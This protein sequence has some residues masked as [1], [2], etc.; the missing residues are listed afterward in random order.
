VAAGGADD[1][2]PVGIVHGDGGVFAVVL[3][4][5]SA[6]AAA[7]GGAGEARR[8]WFA[9]LRADA[10]GAGRAW[11]ATAWMGAALAAAF[12]ALA[13]AGWPEMPP[14]AAWACLAGTAW[15][16]AGLWL[17]RRCRREA[18][19]TGGAHYA[20]RVALVALGIW[21]LWGWLAQTSGVLEELSA[22][23]LAPLLWGLVLWPAG[24]VLGEALAASPAPPPRLLQS[25]EWLVAGQRILLT[26]GVA[27]VVTGILVEMRKDYPVDPTVP[28]AVMWSMALAA[29]VAFWARGAVRAAEFAPRREVARGLDDPSES[30][31]DGVA[32][33]GDALHFGGDDW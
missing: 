11:G 14:F 26:L 29:I 9:A 32:P 28:L 8:G 5:M 15:V 30:A 27:V 22:Y 7:K 21:M 16:L 24:R 17:V 3:E 33:H 18:A 10:E 4:E 12:A 23:Q 1:R 25:R 6:R 19:W 20:G 2:G 31:Q 13:A